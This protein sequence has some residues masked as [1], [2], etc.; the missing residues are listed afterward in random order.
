MGWGLGGGEGERE[1]TAGKL[2]GRGNGLECLLKQKT[3]VWE[4]LE[5]LRTRNYILIPF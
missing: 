5:I 3:Q 4:C 2:D 1:G